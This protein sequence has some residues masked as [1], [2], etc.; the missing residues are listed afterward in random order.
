VF[1][2]YPRQRYDARLDTLGLAGRRLM[3]LA[4]R[5][6]GRHPSP[7]LLRRL[8][9]HPSLERQL[10]WGRVF[11]PEE[12]D[13]LATIP[14]PDEAALAALHDPIAAIWHKMASC[15]PVNARLWGD[16]ALF[17]PGDL[18]PKVDRMSMAHSLEVRVPF[19]DNELVT[20]L[21]AL[22]GHLKVGLRRGKLLLRRAVSGLLP[23]AAVHRRKQG[24]DVPVA[25][26]LR[27]GLRETLL[28][29][30]S[31]EAVQR[32]GLF[33][34]EAVGQLLRQHLTEGHDH[35][36]R[37]WALLALELWMQRA[38]DRTPGVAA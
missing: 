32:R 33:R 20:Y 2:G 15:D 26:W 36:E 19:L 17:L 5:L 24:F 25:A 23:S 7:R 31:P 28:D 8:E 29:S 9:M 14:L 10:D 1:G 27:G 3:P 4:M 6:A 22:P 12:I 30:L 34:P 18:L 13:S 37:L 35:G 21:A 38:L 16:L 11:L